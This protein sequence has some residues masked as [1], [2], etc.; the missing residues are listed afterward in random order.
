M[1]VLLGRQN[2][3]IRLPP[4]IYLIGLIDIEFLERRFIF[5]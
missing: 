2:T 4:P 3:L 1:A 5:N